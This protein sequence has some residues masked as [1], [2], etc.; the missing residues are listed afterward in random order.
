MLPPGPREPA[1]AQ[2]L[3]WVL[4]PT[5]LLR[6]CHARHGDAFTLR[7]S[8]DDAPTV[9]LSSPAAVR[10]VW[11][12]GPG[13][14]RRGESPGPLRRVTGAR[15]IV[16]AD[17]DEHLRIRRLMLPPLH[18][19]RLAAAVPEVARLSRE[20]VARWPRDRPVALA[21]E[22]RRLTLDVILQAAFGVRDERLATTIGDALAFVRSAPRMAAM[23][24]GP[25]GWRSFERRIAAVDAGLREVVARRRA[26]P[27]PGGDLLGALLAAR[28]ARGEPLSDDELRDHLVTLLAAGHDTTAAAAAWALERLAR[29]PDW[30]ARLRAG[31]EAELDAVARETLRVRP[32][33][34]VAPRKLAAPLA[35]G[36]LEL[37]AG[38]HVAP[39][40]YLLHRRA[41]LYRDA[42]AW[43]PERWLGELGPVPDAGAWIPF[44][45]GVRRC[46]GAAFALV[47][48]REIVRAV[49]ATVDL[50]PAAP[51]GERMRRRGVTLNP[52]AGA[53]LVVR[54]A[55]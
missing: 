16:S 34:T 30:V 42:L 55:R 14:L 17:G 4:R 7:L 25:V 23:A 2:T 45:G 28:D 33:L 18:S 15:S 20:A 1:A 19:E 35:A 12:A 29:R 53:R 43:R 5:A 36:G 13:V 50:R 21:G 44:G 48:L 27:E 46:V 8:F 49:T 40:I 31:G 10:D 41:D 6:R 9:L 39:C 54:D 22:L 26:A 37:P 24:L 52:G 38:I 47:E 3:E 51:R 11:A 32:V